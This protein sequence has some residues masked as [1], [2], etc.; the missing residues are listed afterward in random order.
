MKDGMRERQ[1]LNLAFWP[2]LVKLRLQILNFVN[3]PEIVK[4]HEAAAGDV[5][6]QTSRLFVRQLE[7]AGF[8]KIDQRVIKQPI[9]HNRD[10]L[11]PGRDLQICSGPFAK[12]D[13][14]I[15]VGFG[16][17]CG[18]CATT[19]I[20]VTIVRRVVDCA[21]ESELAERGT[22]RFRPDQCRPLAK[23]AGVV[24]GAL[25]ERGG[26][27]KCQQQKTHAQLWAKSHARCLPF[28]LS[29]LTALVSPP[30]P[31]GFL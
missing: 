21:N 25:G 9:I 14:Q 20:T 30:R 23:T 17:V 3:T 15:V 7:E 1:F 26:Q 28:S 29:G 12:S 8:D 5:F 19:A 11:R 24:K 27:K 10:L 6:S 31:I 16:I 4:K 13:N 22:C 18:P 2:D